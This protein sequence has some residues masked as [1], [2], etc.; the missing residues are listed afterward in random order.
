VTAPEG[1]SGQTIVFLHGLGRTR[2]SMT[3]LVREATKRGYGVVNHGYPSRRA[4]VADHASQLR[5]VVEEIGQ[6][7]GRIHF[8]THS[9]G[10]IVVRAMLANRS[11]WPRSLGRVVMLSPPNQ[12]SELADLLASNRVFQLALGPAALELGTG[13]NS[14]PNQLGAVDFEL[15]VITGD[16]TLLPI[17]KRIFGGPG[18]GK[19]SV[20][21][22][23]VEGMRDFLVVR[24]SH[25]FIMRAPDVIS[26]VFDFLESGSFASSS[27]GP[28]NELLP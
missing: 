9:L 27:A 28:L 23:R 6:S 16:R 5:T 14:T 17:G 18:D 22:A 2:Y 25:T 24:R 10:G 3:S 1:R 8:V 7:G 12:G 26:A 4:R 11:A 21:R 15:G 13:P 19:V 20:E